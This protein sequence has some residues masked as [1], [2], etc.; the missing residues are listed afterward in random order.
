MS[1]SSTCGFKVP[2]EAQGLMA[3]SLV[4]RDTA[5]LMVATL[6]TSPHLFHYD[7][8]IVTLPAVLWFA[9]PG[10]RDDPGLKIVLALGFVW[11]AFSSLVADVVHL[12]LTPLLL[13]AWL[14][15]ARRA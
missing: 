9:T 13:L 3:A 2:S 4:M 12:Q 11:L 8:V 6:L 7:M 1:C 14:L 5:A 15:I 10:D